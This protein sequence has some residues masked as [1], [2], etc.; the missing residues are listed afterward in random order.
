[1]FYMKENWF[2]LFFWSGEFSTVKMNALFIAFDISFIYYWLLIHVKKELLILTCKLFIL[3]HAE[4]TAVQKKCG[5]TGSAANIIHISL[6]PDHSVLTIFFYRKDST[7]QICHK[8][9]SKKETDVHVWEVQH[10]PQ[11]NTVY[12]TLNFAEVRGEII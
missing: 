9:S 4:L 5:W 11:A 7:E 2:K 10:H 8:I 6:S 12:S 1:M 3:V